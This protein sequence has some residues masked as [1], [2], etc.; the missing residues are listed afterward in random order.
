MPKFHVKDTF[1][2]SGHKVFFLAGTIVEGTIRKGMFV[3]VRC[4]SALDIT[5]RIHSIEFARRKGGEDV[6]LGIEG[7]A[8]ELDFWR[9]LNIR[10]E[11]LEISEEGSGNDEI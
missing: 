9:A 5:G 6:C 4:N 7:D 8:E 1:E 2:I 11:T 10:D 3:H